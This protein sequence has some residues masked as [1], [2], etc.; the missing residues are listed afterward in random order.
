M[1]SSKR[2]AT[3]A[4]SPASSASQSASACAFRSFSARAKPVASST[5]ASSIAIIFR[6]QISLPWVVSAFS[7]APV[8]PRCKTC[9][10]KTAQSRLNCQWPRISSYIMMPAATAAF[11]DSAPPRMGSFTRQ[12]AASRTAS[13]MPR[14]SLPI[15][16]TNFSPASGRA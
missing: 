16:S 15:T 10:S 6:I 7:I 9:G 2:A 5:S 1:F 3:A 8:P 4:K 11:S 12:S 13:E 14:A